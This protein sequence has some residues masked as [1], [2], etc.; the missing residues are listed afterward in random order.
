MALAFWR[1]ECDRICLSTRRA[2]LRTD[3]LL[4]YRSIPNSQQVTATASM[5]TPLST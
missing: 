2:N 4:L 5:P 1:G 3:A